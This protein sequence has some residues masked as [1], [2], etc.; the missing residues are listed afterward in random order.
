MFVH[1]QIRFFKDLS[2]L[3][4]EECYQTDEIRTENLLKTELHKFKKH[5]S[6]QIALSI[7]HVEFVAH[8]AVQLILNGMWSGALTVKH[9]SLMQCV[10]GIIF[11]PYILMIHTQQ[12]ISLDDSQTIAI[13]TA[14]DDMNEGQ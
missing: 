8:D 10:L 7:N 13:E 11:P 1:S 4:L 9:L 14:E 5:T 12:R 2:V 6:L 3:L